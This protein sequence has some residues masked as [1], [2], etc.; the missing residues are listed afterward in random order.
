MRSSANL[1]RTLLNVQTGEGQLTALLNESQRQIAKGQDAG[2][3]RDL[4]TNESG[5]HQ[6]VQLNP[7]YG[8][9]PIHNETL[10][11]VMQY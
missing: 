1:L 2:I 6:R 11:H 4:I 9:T 8:S 10:P 3:W 5:G 7:S